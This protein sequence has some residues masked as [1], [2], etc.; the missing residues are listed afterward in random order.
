[1]VYVILGWLVDPTVLIVKFKWSISADDI[2]QGRYKLPINTILIEDNG[3]NGKSG[4]WIPCPSCTTLIRVPE[5]SSSEGP[6][7]AQLSRGVAPG[8]DL[9]C[10]GNT[11]VTGLGQGLGSTGRD[12]ATKDDWVNDS[13]DGN[14]R[15]IE[16]V[17]MT[18]AT[19]GDSGD[20]YDR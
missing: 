15:E 4:H 3:Q 16:C 8:G 20:D 14:G 9:M 5:C 13:G 12:E 7:R 18:A 6:R 1:V 19:V 10:D 11:A 2:I 17:V